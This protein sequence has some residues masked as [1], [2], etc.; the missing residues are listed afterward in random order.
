M[1]LFEGEYNIT[2]EKRFAD[3]WETFLCYYMAMI[4]QY[5]EYL[6]GEGSLLMKKI[7][8]IEEEIVTMNQYLH[9]QINNINDSK[10]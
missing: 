8:S 3:R 6:E 1:V 9:Q 4:G 5:K 2:I 10:K 7:S